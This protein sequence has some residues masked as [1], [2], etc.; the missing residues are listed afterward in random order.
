MRTAAETIHLTGVP[1]ARPPLRQPLSLA[2][3]LFLATAVLLTGTLG[4]VLTLATG[5][6]RAVAERTIHEHLGTVPTLWSGYIGSRADVAHRQL[7]FLASEPGIKALLADAGN[8]SAT[9]HDTARGLAGSLDASVI[10]VLDARGLLLERTDREPGAERGRDFSTLSWVAAALEERT[11]APAFILDS[12]RARTIHLVASAPVVQGDGSDRLLLGVIAAAFPMSEVRLREF[13]RIA[14]AETAIVANVARRDA[15]RVM[16]ILASTPALDKEQLYGH[17][18]EGSP[19]FEA[20]FGPGEVARPFEFALR[21]DAFIGSL[22]PLRSGS[23]ET[24]GGLVVARSKSA[25]MAGFNAVRRSLVPIGAGLLATGLVVSFVVARRLTKPIHQLATAA[26]RVAGGEWDVSLPRTSGGDVG[27]L[28]AALATMATELRD[29][30][31]LGAAAAGLPN[32]PAPTDGG[33]GSLGPAET[34]QLSTAPGEARPL[35]RER[36][37]GRRDIDRKSPQAWFQLA[38]LLL[39]MGRTSEAEATFRQALDANPKMASA[40]NALGAI[41]LSRG[42][43]AD[44]EA[45]V[46]RGL[47]LEPELRDARFNL[48]R[49]LQAKGDRD[50]AERQYRDVLTMDPNN[51]RARFNLARLVGEKGDREGYLGELLMSIEMAPSFGP[52]YFLLAREE[53]DSGDRGS[54]EEL[55]LRGLEVDPESEDAPLGHFVLADVYSRQGQAVEAAEEARKGRALEARNRARAK[56]VV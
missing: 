35:L 12:T 38:T 14:R 28:S 52:A 1:A 55:A 44:A 40:Y 8:D 7:R 23:G 45:L 11:P 13:A 37:I 51:A 2:T 32:E 20:M 47:E 29:R 50:G 21:D 26:S 34:L 27:V 49:I 25:E 33:R 19:A 3:K 30:A 17:L 39:D 56:P 42:D 36:S 6:A 9:L 4:L 24:I 10:F 18:V 31:P 5:R 41:A 46:R 53:L 15:P 54:A 16:Q 43:T 22:L 48:A